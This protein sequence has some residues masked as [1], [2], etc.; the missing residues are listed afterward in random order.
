[1]NLKIKHQLII[2]FISIAAVSILVS[3]VL[4]GNNAIKASEKAIQSQVEQKLISVRDLK[5]VQIES[6]FTLIKNQIQIAASSPWVA[7]ATESFSQ[8]MIDDSFDL[9][10]EVNKPLLRKYYTEEFE[11]VF[12]DLNNGHSAN[13][14]KTLE[15]LSDKAWHFQQH[16]IAKNSHPLGEKDRLNQSTV[17]S[18]YDIFH[19]QYHPTFRQFLKAYGYYDVFI[20]EPDSGRVVYSVFKELDFATSLKTG[21]YKD[22]GLAE[23]FHKAIGLNQTGD[24]SFVDFKPYYP[25]YNAAASFISS[26]IIKNGKTIGILIFQMPIDGINDIM[27]NSRNWKETGFGDSGETYLIG[28]DKLLRSQSRFLIEDKPGYLKALNKTLPEDLVS[29]INARDSAIGLQKVDTQ[30]AKN[31]FT[32][33]SGIAY[34]DDYRGIPV[35]S[36]FSP[37]NILDKKWGILSE[38]DQAEAFVDQEELIDSVIHTTIVIA[39]ILIAIMTIVGTYFTKVLIRP[40]TSFSSTLEEITQNKDLTKRISTKDNNEF[41]ILGATLNEMLESLSHLIKDMRNSAETLNNFSSQLSQTSNGTTEKIHAQNLEVN[42]AAAATTQLNT[43]ITEVAK[44]AELAA[45][46]M[47]ETKQHILESASIVNGTRDDIHGLQRNMDNTIKA[48]TTLEE[49]S[50]SIASVLDVIQNIAEQTNLLALNA[51]IEAARA[52]EQGRGFAVVADEVRT[53]ANRTAQST[54]EIRRK[55]TDLQN[56]V[57]HALITVQ[58]SQEK[59]ESSIAKIETTVNSMTEVTTKVESADSMNTQIATAAEEQSQVTNEINNNV[60][61]VKDLSEHVLRF[62]EEIMQTSKNVQNVSDDIYGKIEQFKT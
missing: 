25:S 43:S 41:S 8:A 36:A 52:G 3:S 40:I 17:N 23:A 45:A 20:V 13:I 33:G 31:I 29:E 30:G 42:A 5:K 19:Q 58:Q 21:P 51:A 53:L 7:D 22:T 35:I 38:I 50:Q 49:E 56:G 9:G 26:P 1:M 24:I 11:T 47:N 10:N 28:E 48:M 4:I 44:S 6:Y 32:K 55:I 34:F 15:Q 59:T 61:L 57:E 60:Q 39:L 46:N 14:N 12:K 27:T 62:S 16:Y 2:A 54:E 37:L 18:S